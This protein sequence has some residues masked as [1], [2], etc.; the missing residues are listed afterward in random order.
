MSEK[1]EVVNRGIE[2][3]S[4][5]AQKEETIFL[6]FN[7][8]RDE[9]T[10][11]KKLKDMTLSD[12][13]EL[14]YESL[15]RFIKALKNATGNEDYR[16]AV[17]M[18]YNISYGMKYDE[19]GNRVNQTALFLPLLKPQD[20]TEALLA[21]Q[22]LALREAGNRFLRQS[23]NAE[24]FYHIERCGLLATKLFNVANQTM[25]TLLKYRS[26]NQQTIQVV[27]LHN[28]GGQAIVAQNL[29]QG[30]GDENKS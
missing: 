19:E 15:P 27:H 13:T 21:G 18:L 6:K 4:A 12:G 22:F 23:H 9:K 10:Y 2:S 29:T 24:G 28:G 5:N 16:S 1:S 20:E 26:R 30:G 3:V 17:D 8:E 25:V 14:T 11:E 7:Y